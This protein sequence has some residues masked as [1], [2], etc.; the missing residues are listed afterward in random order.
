[1]K[2][3]ILWMQK[4]VDKKLLMAGL[5]ASKKLAYPGKVFCKLTLMLGGGEQSEDWYVCGTAIS[6]CV[7]P[8]GTKVFAGYFTKPNGKGIEYFDKFGN[9]STFPFIE[10]DTVLYGKYA[11]TEVTVDGKNYLIMRQSDVV[12]IIK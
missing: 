7:L 1:M 3:H 6:P 12:A 4:M 5:D 10:G 9:P 11:G 2:L 8:S